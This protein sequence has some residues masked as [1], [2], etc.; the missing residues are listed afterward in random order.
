M[1]VAKRM[2]YQALSMILVA[3]GILGM[4]NVQ[5]VKTAIPAQSRSEREVKPIPLGKE[6]R[7]DDY[8]LRRLN[9]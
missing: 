7:V 3:L 2:G 9:L 1:N 5:V 6:S 4:W 8:R